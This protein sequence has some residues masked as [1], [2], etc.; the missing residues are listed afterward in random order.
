MS[1]N[2]WSTFLFNFDAFLP[3]LL[4]QCLTP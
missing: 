2:L 1:E 3:L 4:K